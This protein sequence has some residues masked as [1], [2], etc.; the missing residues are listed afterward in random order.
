[1][2]SELI[3]ENVAVI[4]KAHIN[5]ADGFTALTGETGAGKSIIIDSINAVLG[6]RVSKSIV[7]TGAQKASVVAV[8]ENINKSIIEKA[9]E[10]DIDISDECIVTRQITADG[11]S[12]AR[13]NSVP[14]PVSV[15]K[16]LFSNA[17]N[18][19]GQ[20]DSQSL[21]TP[22]KH[23]DILDSFGTDG[24][25]KATYSELYNQYVDISSQISEIESINKDKKD[26]LD[27]LAFQVDEIENA[28]IS[29]EEEADLLKERK[30]A[31]DSEKIISALNQSYGYLSGD[32][33]NIGVLSGL[34]EACAY[35]SDIV[36][37]SDI[38]NSINESLNDS[39]SVI[40]D[41]MYDLKN[42]IDDFDSDVSRLDEI[43][44]RLDVYYKLKNKYGP[45]VSDVLNY[46]N[47]IK[48]DLDTIEFAREKLEKLYSERDM[49]LDKLAISAD[50][51]TQSRKETFDRMASEIQASLRF[52]NMPN[53]KF[54]LSCEKKTYSKD[55]Q[56]SIE[57]LIST[58][59]GE[60]PKPL[61]KIASGGELSRIML[62]IKSVLAE[63]EETYTLI[64]DEI[65]TGVSGSAAT[66]IGKL[67][68]ETSKGKQ[69]LC[70]THS[71]QIAAFSDNHL[72]IE[73]Q[74]DSENTFTNVKL[75]NDTERIR[76]I[77][78]IISGD[79][80]S[81]TALK[82]AEEM[83]EYAHSM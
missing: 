48:N 57:F 83:L 17:I 29:P 55:G 40:Q 79:N 32:D 60:E 7:R 45:T 13:I 18:I 1:M 58:N 22:S 65:D 9:A 78:R 75:L 38:I 56:D 77:A 21:L 35:L 27:L 47:K 16:T 43:E 24:A 69:V 50:R 52:L 28:N 30:I 59:K 26:S 23:I 33:D 68:K 4:K 64:F 51:L 76:E 82:N 25:V 49:I 73:K 81:E 11:K 42:Y 67:L 20:H 41:S 72:Y 15:L 61:S 62:A 70:V 5:F 2:L 71:A 34:S 6:D 53:V 66:K 44:D 54:V 3:I 80:I 39:L 19:H 63:K 14:C 10:M 46:Y 74:F 36:S 8:F 31:R 12:T 37:Y